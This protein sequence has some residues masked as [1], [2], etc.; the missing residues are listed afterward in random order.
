MCPWNVILIY[1]GQDIICS[2]FGSIGVQNPR[3]NGCFSAPKMLTVRCYSL[4]Y[5]SKIAHSHPI[6]V[7][8]IVKTNCSVCKFQL[9]I[10]ASGLNF[11]DEMA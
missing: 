9:G 4:H 5:G 11:Q 7:P 8:L 6:D 2:W 10:A 1:V 3:E